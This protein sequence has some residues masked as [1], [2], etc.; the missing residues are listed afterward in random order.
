MK[1]L[2]VEDDPGVRDGLA[3]VL[4]E[5]APVQVT[6]TLD[7]ALKALRAQP[8][9]L[10]FADLNLGRTAGGVQILEAAQAR[11]VPVIICTGVSRAEAEATLGALRPDA[12]VTK[13]FSIDDV[14]SL[15]NRLFKK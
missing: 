7:G 3:D 2:L 4:G 12:I 10:V 8:F 1:L 15:A 14:I 13:P 6:T 5:V 9:G 11:G